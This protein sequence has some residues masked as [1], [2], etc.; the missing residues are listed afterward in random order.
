MNRKMIGI[1]ILASMVSGFLGGLIAESMGRPAFSE[2]S[3]VLKAGVIQAQ[4]ILL[5]DPQ[6]NMR[7]NLNAGNSG[8]ILEMYDSQG[9]RRVSLGFINDFTG[10][11]LSDSQGKRKMS[12]SIDKTRSL[13][14][15]F[16][17]H[18]KM[19]MT[20]INSNHFEGFGLLDSNERVRSMIG[21]GSRKP[22]STIQTG[23]SFVMFFDKK[24]RVIWQAPQ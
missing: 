6:G 17:A 10:L 20:L 19:R 7:V 4:R 21:W 18:G 8:S 14:N 15:F 9:N 12:L 1:V 16:D 2:T 3:K 5:T 11:A 13:A 23:E 22:G 24:G